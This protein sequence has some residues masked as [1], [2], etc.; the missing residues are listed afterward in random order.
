MTDVR[1]EYY[2]FDI[3][4][5]ELPFV[6]DAL[7]LSESDMLKTH[8][9]VYVRKCAK[10]LMCFSTG[11]K[12]FIYTSATQAKN[13]IMALNLYVNDKNA[14]VAFTFKLLKTKSL[15]FEA[16]LDPNKGYWIEDITGYSFMESTWN[17]DSI[18]EASNEFLLPGA[19]GVS[20]TISRTHKEV[21]DAIKERKERSTKQP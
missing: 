15:K 16:A 13:L 12:Y 7:D 18:S 6:S 2:D 19:K 8:N 11:Y 21:V 3:E 1:F 9:L 14:N 17:G 5:F 4:Y 20:E 10:G